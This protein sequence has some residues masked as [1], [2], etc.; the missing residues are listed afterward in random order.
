MSAV[1]PEVSMAGLPRSAIPTAVGV[2][3]IHEGCIGLRD[4]L[5]KDGGV[6][7]GVGRV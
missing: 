7:A 6:E 5:A 3:D 2:Y 1:R 4:R